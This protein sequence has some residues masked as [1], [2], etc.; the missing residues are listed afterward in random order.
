[1]IELNNVLSPKSTLFHM[2]KINFIKNSSK[3]KAI[4][5]DSFVD[6]AL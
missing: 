6:H 4:R 1:M 5:K 3:M 2:I